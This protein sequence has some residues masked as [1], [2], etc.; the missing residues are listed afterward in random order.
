MALLI[1]LM[2]L[3]V[4]IPVPVGS[5]LKPSASTSTVA[6]EAY[7]KDYLYFDAIK[8]VTSVSVRPNLMPDTSFVL[9][10]VR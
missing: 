10:R 9:I 6:V 7:S 2:A 1:G 8:Y 3:L 5:S 4:H